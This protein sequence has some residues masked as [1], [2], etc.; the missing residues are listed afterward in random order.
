MAEEPFKIRTSTQSAGHRSSR[1]KRTVLPWLVLAGLASLLLVGG[2]I[3]LT[4][5]A[6]HK[7]SSGAET[8]KLDQSS[9]KLL[10]NQDARVATNTPAEQAVASENPRELAMADDGASL[11]ISPTAGGPVS[12]NYLP[13]ATQFILHLRPAE[14]LGHTEGEKV[15]AA[16]GPWAQQ[17]TDVLTHWTGAHLEEISSLTVAVY[18]DDDGVLA[19]SLR[20][21]LVAPWTEEQ[22]TTRIAEAVKKK[23]G[24]QSFLETLGRACYL[25]TAAGGNLLVSCPQG[26]LDELIR[27]G[28]QASLFPRDMQRLLNGTDANRMAT[29]VFPNKFL[30]ISGY[31]LLPGSGKR[32]LEAFDAL[33]GDDAA[34][35]A[36][37]AHLDE[38]FFL[39]MQSTVNLHQRPHVFAAAIARRMQIFPDEMENALHAEPAHPFGRKVV[40]RFPNMLRKLSNYTRSAEI[41]GVTVLRCYLPVSAGHNLLMA[42][43]L[44]LHD[45][46]V[47]SPIAS[48]RAVTKPLGVDERLQKVTSLAF[49]KES[50]QQALDMLAEDLGLDIRIAGGDLQLEGIT[51]NQSLTLNMRDRT[52]AEI[53]VEVLRKA[54]P[55]QTATGPG[56]PKQKLVYLVSNSAD[57]SPAIIVTTRSAALKRGDS[58]P[59]VFETGAK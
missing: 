32:L 20:V 31:K 38:N 18:P 5:R 56:D 46:A 49:P 36:F 3:L 50:L 57:P 33:A 10:G 9:A 27:M 13:P 4:G 59:P 40:G 37:S 1:A 47:T 22:L 21:A 30:Q 39:E 51:K 34:T 12:L 24:S 44:L 16:L 52:A 15:L 53:L 58:L 2:A 42:T 43:E 11:W 17:A 48:A 55:D 35:V 14:L 28:D 7:D 54:N 6:H 26:M 23:M 19:Y 25:P 8:A 29:L 45:F 41:E